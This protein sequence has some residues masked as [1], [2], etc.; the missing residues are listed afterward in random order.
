MVTNKIELFNEN[1]VILSENEKLNITI[2]TKYPHT[3]FS[4]LENVFKKTSDYFEGVNNV[5][6]HI[7]NELSYDIDTITVTSRDY[8]KYDFSAISKRLKDS[9]SDTDYRSIE[10]NIYDKDFKVL[11]TDY[12]SS[13]SVELF[14]DDTSMKYIKYS[15]PRITSNSNYIIEGDFNKEKFEDFR[16]IVKN[17]IPDNP[18]KQLRIYPHSNDE[19]MLT[20][21]DTSENNIVK[22]EIDIC[23]FGKINNK[24]FTIDSNI[25][26]DN[27]IDVIS[28]YTYENFN[29]DKGFTEFTE[30]FLEDIHKKGYSDEYTYMFV[31]LTGEDMEFFD[32]FGKSIGELIDISKKESIAIDVAGSLDF[33]NFTVEYC[34]EYKDITVNDSGYEVI[35]KENINNAD[36]IDLSVITNKTKDNGEIEKLFS[37]ILNEIEENSNYECIIN[38]ENITKINEIKEPE[39]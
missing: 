21:S 20:V 23:K 37:D 39:L 28:D 22:S 38:G 34:P 11:I 36:N 19:T 1:T 17:I 35:L 18:I 24:I 12:K 26:I 15:N 4:S 7:G 29:E 8:E 5:I 16:N 33:G 6:K 10:H 3:D 25:N 9:L 31:K 13:Q 14:K 32:N 30:K 27:V 2:T